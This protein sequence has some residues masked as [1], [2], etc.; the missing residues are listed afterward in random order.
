VLRFGRD[1]GGNV[2]SVTDAL[3][4]T[5]RF[6]YDPLGRLSTVTD[7]LDGVTRLAYDAAG[8]LASVTD[9]RGL[10]TTYASD[11]FGQDW[12]VS[13][14]DSGIT[15]TTWDAAGR[16]TSIVRGYGTS[17]AATTSFDYDTLGRVVRANA[18]G[19]AQVFAYDTCGNGL[20]RLCG[21]TDR[22]GSVAYAYNDNGQVT[23][24]TTQFVDGTTSRFAFAYDPSG[25]KTL[26][27][28]LST[29]VRTTYAY[30]HGRLASVGV[31]IGSAN[32]TVRTGFKYRPFGPAVSWSLG[33]GLAGTRE[34]DLDGR[35]VATAT[36][37]SLHALGFGYD[38]ADQLVSL[39][40]SANPA[41][42]QAYTYDALGRLVGASFGNGAGETYALDATGN[43]KS[44]GIGGVQRTLQVAVSSNRINSVTASGYNRTFSYDAF[45]NRTGDVGSNGTLTWTYDPFNRME[46]ATRNSATTSYLV[47]ALGQR[48]YKAGA[49]GI[50]R[51][52][53]SPSGGLLAESRSGKPSTDYVWAAG[54]VVAIVRSG[55]VH[56]LHND[57]L[58][59]PEVA[60]NAAKAV[61]WRANN[62]PFDRTVSLDS[63]GGLGLGLPGQVFDAETGTWNN[64]FRDYD[65][66]LGGY[67]QSDPAGLAGGM[68][69]Y[70]YVGG[71]PIVL[72]DP[73]GLCWE[74]SQANGTLTHVDDQ[75]GARD[76]VSDNGYAGHGEGVNN[77][78][79]QDVPNVGP[80]PRGEYRIGTM[81]DNRT[82]SG[83]TLRNSMRLSPASTNEM[84]GR[85]GFLIHGDNNRA[86]RSASRGCPVLPAEARDEIA[87]SGDN[88]LRVVE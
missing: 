79:M 84:H 23:T 43:R 78:D 24:Q 14:P 32:T 38:A 82:S 61:V 39:A 73:F 65:P 83:H 69:S 85:S 3:G 68:N 51:S 64:G 4:R 44:H 26:A 57:H 25:R 33:N 20:Q 59:R 48:T 6:A 62:G 55:A 56:Y 17:S 81:R 31:G 41:M 7:A 1:E 16:R 12:T 5:S 9:A 21:V 8:N 28:D 18:G 80:L 42:T 29:N 15:R 87:A 30:D 27:H 19:D 22:S 67:L 35:L 74:Y 2:V 66:S 75:S 52:T 34:Y 37:P 46:T 40:N 50:V 76:L 63:I 86:D 47:N 10:A 36:G 45:G 60:T 70:T 54:E 49:G 88:C 11:G 53:W 58:G 71:N 13:S 77:P 72:V